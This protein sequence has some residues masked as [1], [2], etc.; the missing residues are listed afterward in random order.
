[1]LASVLRTG[2]V[3]GAIIRGRSG[4]A[5]SDGPLLVWGEQGLGDQILYASII[6]DLSKRVP[7]IVLEAERRLTPLFARSFPSVQI[8]AV[9]AERYTKLL[10]PPR[11]RSARSANSCAGRGMSFRERKG[12]SSKPI[13]RGRA[14]LHERL[15]TDGRLVVGLSWRSSNKKLEKA[16]SAGLH[17][18]EP[19][20]KLQNCR[21]VDLQYGDT[22]AERAAVARDIGVES[23]ISTISTICRTSTASRR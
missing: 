23:S 22:S 10:V 12:A 20:L 16:K 11:F 13:R 19:L 1:M 6:P 7:S 18:F 14:A 8:V 2:R 4:T 9:G 17:A 21:F 15:K 3:I 5:E